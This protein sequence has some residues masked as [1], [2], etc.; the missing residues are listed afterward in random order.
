MFIKNTEEIIFFKHWTLLVIVKGQS[1][2]LVYLNIY[3]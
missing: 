2:H 1:S 3:A